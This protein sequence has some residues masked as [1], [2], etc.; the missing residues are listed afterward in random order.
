MSNKV[1]FFGSIL[2]ILAFILGVFLGMLDFFGFLNGEHTLNLI[3]L[4]LTFVTWHLLGLTIFLLD[5]ADSHNE[6]VYIVSA[7]V[8]G[9]VFFIFSHNPLSAILATLCFFLFQIYTQH[10]LSARF[11]LFV[12]YS[13]RE[14][15][16]P[17]I[18]RSF[19]FLMVILLLIGF[20][21]GRGATQ[22][23]GLVT[24]YL[25][26]TVAKPALM[27][28]NKQFSS[29]LQA[30]FGNRFASQI[31]TNDRRTIVT[32]VL[33]EALES[34]EEGTTRQY[35]GVTKENIPLD[36]TIIYDSGEIDLTPVVD[37]M[38]PQIAEAINQRLFMYL[39]F[40]PFIFGLLVLAFVS[41]LITLSELLLLPVIRLIIG[42]L[43]QLGVITIAHE[44][45]ERETL[46][47]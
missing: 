34:F 28:I 45:V 33:N 36:Q 21:Q 29:Q 18:R 10:K 1:L 25:V 47:L 12:N 40:L 14:I 27:I 35:F 30:S 7:A 31:G 4:A 20:I 2:T 23:T 24:P 41:P 17:V 13:T 19:L 3:Y 9:M 6:T 16:F 44:T 26:R 37:S 39:P 11:R 22:K 8:F 43:L 32:L 46:K 15:V 38:A 42:A 5:L